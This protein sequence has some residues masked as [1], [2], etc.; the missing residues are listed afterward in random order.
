MPARTSESGIRALCV[1]GIEVDV[2]HLTAT[3]SR[4]VGV[5][6]ALTPYLGYATAAGIA[7][8]ALAGGMEAAQ[9]VDCRRAGQL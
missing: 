7:K 6:T 3:A 1:D 9:P 4:S 2:Q 5:V 8:A